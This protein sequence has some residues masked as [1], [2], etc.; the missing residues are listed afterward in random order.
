VGNKIT[1]LIKTYT[2][3]KF[4]FTATTNAD[5]IALGSTVGLNAILPNSAITMS[6]TTIISTTGYPSPYNTSWWGNKEQYLYTAAE[7]TAKGFVAGKITE[8]GLSVGSVTTTLPLTNFTIS[9]G[10]TT[11]TAMSTSFVTTGMNNVYMNSSYTVLPNQIN[12][13]PFQ[14]PFIW[15]GVS[16]I[17][18]ETCFNN[19]AY[20]GSQTI[21]YSTTSNVSCAYSYADNPTVCSNPV[22]VYTSSNRP[23]F[24]ISQPLTATYSWSSSANGGLVSTNIINP[25]AIPTGT[26][27]LYSY[28]LA[29][30]NAG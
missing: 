23:N 4:F 28:I 12:T 19:A 17:V 29:A 10:H 18:I 25:N 15:D 3:A 16:N 9:I 20:N 7:L 26:A 22:T 21:T 30:T 2:D 5:T 24:I 6:G 14:T 27:G 8:L 1:K 11:L 13:H